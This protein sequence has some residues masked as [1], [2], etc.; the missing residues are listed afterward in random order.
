MAGWTRGGCGTG[1]LLPVF[2]WCFLLTLKKRRLCSHLRGL[3]TSVQHGRGSL[4]V[5]LLR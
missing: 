2:V 1:G 5:S 4:G 3:D